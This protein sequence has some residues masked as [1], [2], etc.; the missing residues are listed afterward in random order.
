MGMMSL[1]HAAGFRGMRVLSLESRRADQMEQM[2]RH[3][4]GEPFVAPSVK[5]IPFQDH[6]KVYAWAEELF[7][8]KFDLMILMTGTGLAFLRDI[9]AERYPPERFAEALRSTTLLSRGPKPAVTLRE[10]GITPQIIVPEPNTWHEIVQAV[11]ARTERRIALQEYGQAVPQLVDALNQLGAQVTTIAI[12]RWALPDDLSP[13]QEAV[14]RI[15][16]RECDVVLFTT[17][18]Q[19]TH[20]LQVAASMGREPEVRSALAGYIAI[21]SIGPVMDAALAD[22]GLAPDIVPAHPNMPV[23][24]RTAAENAASALTHKRRISAN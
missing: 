22:Y 7:N 1:E 19:L 11:A 12:Y 13:L 20:L 9:L 18:I 10:M 15:A 14:R 2:I 4:G 24:V 16:E 21:G 23:L 3:H 17:S 6:H 8:G 5:E